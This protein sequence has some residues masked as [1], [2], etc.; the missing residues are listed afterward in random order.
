MWGKRIAPQQ[1]KLL[2]FLPGSLLKQTVLVC[3]RD[4]Y[5]TPKTLSI[6]YNFRQKQPLPE[7]LPNVYL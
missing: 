5:K 4:K 7:I 3:S 6:S 1:K 2:P